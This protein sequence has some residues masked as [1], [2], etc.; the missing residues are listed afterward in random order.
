M[1][2]K[3][4]TILRI[5]LVSVHMAANLVGSVRTALD[6]YQMTADHGWSDSIVTL[7]WI[8]EEVLTNS[9]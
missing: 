7:H 9:S 5:E 8:K 2:K 3:N 6:G 1:A 4:L